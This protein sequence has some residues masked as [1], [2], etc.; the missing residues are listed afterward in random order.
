MWGMGTEEE[1]QNEIAEDGDESVEESGGGDQSEPCEK[2][3]STGS[4]KAGSSG[5]RSDEEKRMVKGQS[6]G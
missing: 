2:W 5:D 6:D 4:I 1:V 3:R